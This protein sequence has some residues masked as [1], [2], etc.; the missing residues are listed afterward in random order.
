MFKHFN[1]LENSIRISK[2]PAY[3][4]REPPILLNRNLI[5]L[6]KKV[7]RKILEEGYFTHPFSHPV[8]QIQS[9]LSLLREHLSFSSVLALFR[10]PYFLLTW[11]ITKSCNGSVRV[12]SDYLLSIIDTALYLS[13]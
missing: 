11:S 4:K 3:Y 7:T 5:L 6:K 2:H 9:P 10:M 1:I 13:F 12:Q 8:M